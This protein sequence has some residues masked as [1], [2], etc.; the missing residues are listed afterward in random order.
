MDQL[1]ESLFINTFN[2]RLKMSYA[3]SVLLLFAPRTVYIREWEIRW[4]PRRINFP[5]RLSYL[6]SSNSSRCML[7]GQTAK[8]PILRA[9]CLPLVWKQIGMKGPPKEWFLPA[10][11][12]VI[13]LPSRGAALKPWHLAHKQMYHLSRWRLHGLTIT[14]F[15]HCLHCVSHLTENK[16]CRLFHQHSGEEASTALSNTAFSSRC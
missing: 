15:D 10:N 7:A 8:A 13:Y 4:R 9:Q 6:V 5:W 2:F 1:S 12:L 14:G 11:R 16:S 3:E